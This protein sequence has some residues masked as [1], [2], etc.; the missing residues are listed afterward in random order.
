MGTGKS[1]L[2]PRLARRLGFR[3]LD[4]DQQIAHRA[5]KSIPDIFREE[6]E[7]AFRA[8]EAQEVGRVASQTG[9][10]VALGGGAVANADLRAAIK[11]AGILVCLEVS[12]DRLTARL[13]RSNTRRPL[14]KGADGEP[15]YGDPLRARIEELLADRRHAY[16]DAHVTVNV[17]ASSKGKAADRLLRAIEGYQRLGAS[18][19]GA[20]LP[21]G[22][23][24]ETA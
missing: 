18:G 23:S 12:I 15:L 22:P 9:I 14:L 11:A 10:V 2:G 7:T 24:G 3:F 21:S 19:P 4:L 13:G 5:G 1:T 16:E 17:E 20:E 8:L 6:G